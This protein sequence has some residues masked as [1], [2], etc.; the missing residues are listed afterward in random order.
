MNDELHS[1]LFY[2]WVTTMNEQ[3]MEKVKEQPKQRKPRVT[4]TAM[5][6]EFELASD[7]LTIFRELLKNYEDAIGDDLPI[8]IHEE[9]LIL[10]SMDASRVKMANFVFYKRMFEEWHVANKTKYKS[11]ELPIRIKVP[12]SDLIYAIDDAG[13]DAKA[14]FYITAVFATHGS[15]TTVKVRKPEKCPQC[16][17]YT[18]DN[19]LP[20]DKRG[21]KR[22]RYKCVCGWRGKVRVWERKERVITTEPTN[23]SSIKIDV[24][25][26]TKETY[27]VKIFDEEISE[28]PPLPIIHYDAHFK[29]LG[30][31]FKAKLE[32]L[33]KRTDHFKINGSRDG[34][35]LDGQGDTIDVSIKIDKG[36]DILLVAD[37]DGVSTATFSLG[38]VLPIMPKPS[39]AQIIGI[40]YSTNMP[41]RLTWQIDKLGVDCLTEYYVAPRIETD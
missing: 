18:T 9:K 33:Q 28:L 13:K 15:W 21:K 36:S 25:E 1:P 6:V 38:E 23:E 30:K 5:S 3:V 8:E 37:A 22:N 7:A 26:R 11:A 29:L 35:V 2:R 31:D 24:M 16:S 14:R 17:R 20:W 39:V 4:K 32:R 41:I 12:I 19:Q 40:D 10:R 27:K 34:L